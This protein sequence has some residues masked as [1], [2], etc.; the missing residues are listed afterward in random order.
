LE[1]RTPAD[2]HVRIA[3]YNITGQIVRTIKNGVVPAGAHTTYWNGTNDDGR[4]V[5]NGIY[6]MRGEFGGVAAAR[7]VMVIK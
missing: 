4:R 1:Y 5:A 6:V 3:V 2:G 7:K